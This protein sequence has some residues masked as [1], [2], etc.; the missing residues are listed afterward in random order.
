MLDEIRKVCIQA[1]SAYILP[2][3]NA[4][5]L[6]FHATLQEVRILKE[7]KVV[8]I[9]N[10]PLIC[11]SMFT[12]LFNTCIPKTELELTKSSTFSLEIKYNELDKL[13]AAY[14]KLIDANST[15]VGNL[16]WDVKK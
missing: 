8:L 6:I 5:G 9:K 11:S 10:H 15:A 14:R 3:A 16:Q 13:L 7:S 12:H 4:M 2:G 1:T